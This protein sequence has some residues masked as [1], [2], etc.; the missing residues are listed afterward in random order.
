MRALKIFILVIV[1]LSG[2]GIAQQTS[3]IPS[4]EALA[5]R[6]EASDGH[7][8]VHRETCQVKPGLGSSRSRH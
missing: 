6:W 7:L 1:L 5:G 2:V 4:P 8:G 3:P